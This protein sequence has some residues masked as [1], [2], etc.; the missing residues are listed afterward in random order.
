MK[1][2][3]CVDGTLRFFEDGFWVCDVCGEVW[4]PDGVTDCEGEQAES[5]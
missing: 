5:D 2:D 4:D 1:C 3:E